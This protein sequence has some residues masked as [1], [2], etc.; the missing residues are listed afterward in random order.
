MG[1]TTLELFSLGG[2]LLFILYYLSNS[3][4]QKV[5]TVHTV[6]KEYI[7]VKV[8]RIQPRGRPWR[9]RGRR[10]PDSRR[11]VPIKPINTIPT[12]PVKGFIQGETY[13]ETV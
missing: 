9:R 2:I 3:E 6:Q 4:V 12:V 11:I 7:P 13:H 10:R 1:L 5:R 8:E